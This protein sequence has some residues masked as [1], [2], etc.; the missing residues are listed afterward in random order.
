MPALPPW[1]PQSDGWGDHHDLQV[2]LSAWSFE[3]ALATYQQAGRL[4]NVVPHT[5]LPASLPVALNTTDIAVACGAPGLL[6]KY[7]KMWMQLAVA[8]EQGATVSV[9]AKE[10]IRV[11]GPISVVFQAITP[12][13]PKDA[14]SLLVNVSVAIQASIIQNGTQQV[15]AGNVTDGHLSAAVQNSTVGPV[16]LAAG[17]VDLLGYVMDSVLIP[18]V[19]KKMNK[20]IFPLP[21]SKQ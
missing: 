18:A 8:V 3:T 7:P 14:F 1:D 20:G 10:G 13:G 12:Q 5:A 15:L 4:T 16:V 21:G 9:T 11:A 17:G 2:A 19:N 6:L